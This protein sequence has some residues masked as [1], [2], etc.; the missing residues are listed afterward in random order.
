[1]VDLLELQDELGFNVYDYGARNYDA[2]IGRWMIVDPLAEEFPGWNPYHY[3][4]NNPMNLIDPTGMI[5]EDWV[6]HATDKGEKLLTYDPFVHSEED[7]IGRGYRNVKGV[8]ET[9]SY[10]GT[11][12]T[13]SY[14]L[15]ANGSVTDNLNGTTTDVGFNAIRTSD[16]FYISEN[17]QLKSF[18][19]G[20]QKAGDRMTYA[21]LALSITGVGAP[22]GG[23]MMSVGGGM[24]L[25]GAG[26]ES[27][28]LAGQGEEKKAA[29][30]FGLSIFFARS[31]N[32]GVQATERAIGKGV[33]T[34]TKTL[35]EGIN[36]TTEKQIGS[37]IEKWLTK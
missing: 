29:V 8:S 13:E 19:T 4:H 1:M 37:E 14:N 5:G 12:G 36:I 34:S 28:F 15:N 27:L 32:Y 10:N 16:G 25:V 26:I 18:S 3:V 31:G 33:N 21:G 6:D 30:K 23:A 20:L 9:M 35:I 24:S 17:S 2:A 7:A 11:S 22:L